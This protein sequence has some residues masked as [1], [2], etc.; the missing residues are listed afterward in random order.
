MS[1]NHQ[2]NLS[3]MLKISTQENIVNTLSFKKKRKFNL[4]FRL[5]SPKKKSA[6]EPNLSLI[7]SLQ[8]DIRTGKICLDNLFDSNKLE[9]FYN[10]NNTKTPEKTF[11]EDKFKEFDLF[12]PVGSEKKNG[13]I[14]IETDTKVTIKRNL[15]FDDLDDVKKKKKYF[16]NLLIFTLFSLFQKLCEI[17]CSK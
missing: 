13:S 3:P 14:M 8:K 15:F 5:D 12:T 11:S 6:L 17:I 2:A 7:D 10:S 1:K 4:E 9:E 16:F